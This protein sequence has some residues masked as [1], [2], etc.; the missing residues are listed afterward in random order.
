MQ[1]GTGAIFLD[2]AASTPIREEV[3]DAM[4][5]YL[6]AKFGNP[7]S[8]HF[9]GR[10]L[11]KTI[12][13]SRD[14]IKNALN[15]S[16]REIVFLS[17]ATEGDNWALKNLARANKDKGRHFIISAFEHHAVIESAE[18][19]EREGYECTRVK[20][21][22]DGVVRVDDIA[23]SIRPD[24]TF[25]SL[26]AVNNEIGTVQPVKEVARLA[27]EKG[28]MMHT[29]CAQAIST[30]PI[31]LQEW[32]VDILT[33]TAHKIYG[34]IGTG[35]NFVR[36]GTSIEPYIH[37]GSHEFGMRAGTEN[38]AGIVGLSKA[39]ELV[40]AEREEKVNRYKTL[41]IYLMDLLKQKMP[42]V[43][44]VGNM[45]KKAPHI[46][47]LRVPGALA[48]N[49]LIGFDQAG[50]AI[51]TGS[52]CASGSSEPS[53]VMKAIDY[54]FA[55]ARECIRISFGI[56]TEKAH[57]DRFAEVLKDITTRGVQI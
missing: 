36:K 28:L 38:V 7:S 22:A 14:R 40:V 15:C 32:Q 8:I 49:L 30:Q 25:I 55:K 26:M 33:A 16:Y 43:I 12:D 6:S 31:D 37:G 45:E 48:E 27:K 11:R 41:G 29:D 5:P 18:F 10:E 3:R 39:V 1:T 47:N 9:F 56:Y 46:Y 21:A 34:P 35:F 17:G 50:I 24:T 54:D 2:Y 52:A 19:L 53:H 4:L 13:E 57:L 23:A 42:E 44:L 51:S 20:P